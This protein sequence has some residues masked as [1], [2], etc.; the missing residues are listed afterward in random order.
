MVSQHLGR[1]LRRQNHLGEQHTGAWQRHHCALS[2]RLAPPR[3]GMSP[4][5]GSCFVNREIVMSAPATPSRG[6]NLQMKGRLPLC[7]HCHGDL[8]AW[9]RTCRLCVGVCGGMGEG[10]GRRELEAVSL[11]WDIEV[12]ASLSSQVQ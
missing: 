4:L 5:V 9:Q 6:K 3:P 7:S 2:T 8:D 1:C 11:Y 12:T 10:R